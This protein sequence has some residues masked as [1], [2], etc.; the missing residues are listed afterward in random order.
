MT[1]GDLATIC[2]GLATSKCEPVG[3]TPVAGVSHRL[4]HFRE[5][6]LFD[7][8]FV[9]VPGERPDP[10]RL[11]AREWR[12]GRT[13]RLF[14]EELL[15]LDSPPYPT[16]PD[17]L[18]VAYYASAELG[19]HLALGWPLP[20][21]ILDLHV[22]FRRRTAG[23]SPPHGNGLLGALAWHGLDLMGSAEKQSMR[24]LIMGG[25]P[26][27]DDERDAI[28]DYCEEDVD[29]LV[30]LLPAMIEDLDLPRALL[31]GRYMAAASRIEW[32][33][34]PIDVEIL[35]RLLGRW[36]D[37]HD[38]LIREVDREYGVFVGRTFKADRWLAWLSRAGLAWPLLASGAPALDDD[39]FREMARAHPE[40]SLMRELRHALSQMRLAELAV[41][42]DGRNRCLLS[43]FGSRTGRN[44]PSNTRFI[45]GPS[46][47]LR[48]LI[49]PS[50]GRAIAYVDYE[51]Q[52]FGIAAAL[53]AD[54]AMRDAYAGGDPYLAFARQAGQIPPG[55]TRES[56]QAVRDL[57]KACVLGVQYG[58]GEA[59]LARRIGRPTVV[60]RDLLRLHR[61]TYPT[62]WRWSD[63]VEQFAM[64]NGYLPT[65]FGWTVRVGSDANPRSLRNFPMQ[66]NGAEMLR[67]A[68][69]LATERSIQVCAPIHD[70]LL[71]E[72]PVDSIHEVVAGTQRATREASEI[73]LGGSALRTE[74]KI[75]R[76]PDR[77]MDDRGRGMWGRVM[78]LLGGPT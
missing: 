6:W 7:F 74:A 54:P 73:V 52:E 16:G 56:H 78:R 24:H 4:D 41:G 12:S 2:P 70:A 45:F 68:C 66:A 55:G 19:C 5:I 28:L 75:V 67:L 22:E 65:T 40:V 60:A 44:Q 39:T 58:M 34:V 72:G 30:R 64:L 20:A 59:S 29:A 23:L 62:F 9:A 37:I 18:F 51:Q 50:R 13:V 43:I 21:R 47:W 57:F 76:W 17:I 48:G 26:Y 71:V 31:R 8:E 69:C 10:V 63:D 53:S 14:R 38:E 32:V 1:A 49:R 11:A 35:S 46:T 3:G 33:G 42:H 15:G 61:E 25:G 36:V 77:Y 27:T